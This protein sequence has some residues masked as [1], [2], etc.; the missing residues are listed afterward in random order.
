MASNGY[1]FLLAHF[2]N[3]TDKRGTYT[4][5]PL[6]NEYIRT[7]VLASQPTL[8]SVNRQKSEDG[9]EPQDATSLHLDCIDKLK[10]MIQ[11]PFVMEIIILSLGNLED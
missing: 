6:C 1:N 10:N 3:P 4:I 2:Q 7:S 5:S 8:L 9:W 11:Q